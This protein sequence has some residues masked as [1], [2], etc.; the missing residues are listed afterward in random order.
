MGRD[1]TLT[2]V[3]AVLGLMSAALLYVALAPARAAESHRVVRPVA[4][5]AGQGAARA[6]PNAE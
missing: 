6:L 2:R 5:R 4:S 1:S 3:A